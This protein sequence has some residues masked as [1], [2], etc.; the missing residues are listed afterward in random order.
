MPKRRELASHA[1]SIHAIRE[2][3]LQEF[4]DVAPPRTKKIPLALFQKR[5]ELPNVSVVSRD[6]KPRQPFL[7]PKII[8]KSG[9]QT[10]I[11]F[12]RHR[13]HQYARYRTLSKV[14]RGMQMK[15]LTI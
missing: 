7:D 9:K 3:L 10:S 2:K 6:R 12:G 15:L 5:S 14:T 1:A 8:E 13:E 11:G 4:A